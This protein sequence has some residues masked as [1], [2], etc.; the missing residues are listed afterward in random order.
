L[1]ESSCGSSPLRLYHKIDKKNTLTGSEFANEMQK[2]HQIVV[3][4]DV[5]K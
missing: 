3:P 1:A 2:S 4:V 5:L